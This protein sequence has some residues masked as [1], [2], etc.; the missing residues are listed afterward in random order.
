[1]DKIRGMLPEKTGEDIYNLWQEYEKA[2]TKEGKFVKGLDKS[3]TLTQLV[4]A[5]YTTYD[6]P[7]FIADYTE[8]A[9]KNFPELKN[10]LLIVRDKLKMEFVKGGFVWKD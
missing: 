10:L 8:E 9:I 1:M 7:D 4:E 3:E 2:S 5:G 6:K